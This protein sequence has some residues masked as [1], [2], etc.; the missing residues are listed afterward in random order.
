MKGYKRVLDFYYGVKSSVKTHGLKYQSFFVTIRDVCLCFLL[1]TVL[2]FLKFISLHLHFNLLFM[3]S[4]LL[5]ITFQ[6]FLCKLNLFS[7]AM[8]Y[9][10]RYIFMN[11]WT[12]LNKSLP[13]TKISLNTNFSLII[14][15]CKEHWI[16][17]KNLCMN[18]VFLLLKTSKF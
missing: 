9:R 7:N 3:M 4:V 2:F 14:D 1:K 13:Q 5:R 17:K 11:F 8:K 15:S 18:F 6:V 12:N 10:L 16:V